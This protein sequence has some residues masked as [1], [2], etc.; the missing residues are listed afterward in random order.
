MTQKILDL[1]RIWFLTHNKKLLGTYKQ[2]GD[3]ISL[4]I[5]IT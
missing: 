5:P 3:L 4:K 1:T 2:Q